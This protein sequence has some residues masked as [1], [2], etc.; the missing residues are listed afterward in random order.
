VTRQKVEQLAHRIG[1]LI[2]E[3]MEVKTTGIVGGRIGWNWAVIPLSIAEW[4]RAPLPSTGAN[5]CSTHAIFCRLANM[6]IRGPN[7]LPDASFTQH[8]GNDE[9]WDMLLHNLRAAL[10]WMVLAGLRIQK[11]K[12]DWLPAVGI[13]GEHSGQFL[14]SEGLDEAGRLLWLMRTST[15][16]ALLWRWRL[17]IRTQMASHSPSSSLLAP[18]IHNF[19]ASGTFAAKLAH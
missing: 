9:H 11:A 19:A 7:A 14:F 1:G 13:V 4:R 8:F 2:I 3:G 6:L 5:W 15:F 18:S 10:Q 16:G 17:L 12:A